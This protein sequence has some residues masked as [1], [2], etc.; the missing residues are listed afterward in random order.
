ME[1]NER[2]E[3]KDRKKSNKQKLVCARALQGKERTDDHYVASFFQS[4]AVKV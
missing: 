2:W 4:Q 3:I 1:K